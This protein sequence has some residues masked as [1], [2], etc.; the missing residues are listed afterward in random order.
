MDAETRSPPASL[1]D[2][3]IPRRSRRDD[4]AKTLCKQGEPAGRH[5]TK[6]GGHDHV[7]HAV[8][9]GGCELMRG[10]RGTGVLILKLAGA[11]HAVRREG[12][13][14]LAFMIRRRPST[15]RERSMATRSRLLSL[16][17]GTRR[18]V[19][20]GCST[21]RSANMTRT[22]ARRSRTRFSSLAIRALR[23][24]PDSSNLGA[25]VTAGPARRSQPAAV[26]RETPSPVAMVMS[27]VSWT[28]CTRRWS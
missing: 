9:L 23:S 20:S 5:M 7:A 28:S 15:P 19:R 27:P 2:E 8:D 26:D 22:M 25:V 6:L 18:R 1:A 3:A 4:A 16:P 24:A 21:R 11:G 12:E 13:R 10:E 14:P 17:F